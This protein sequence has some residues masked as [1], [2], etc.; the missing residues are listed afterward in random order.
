MSD[1]RSDVRAIRYLTWALVVLAGALAVTAII[2]AVDNP[3]ISGTT[4]GDSYPCL[5]PWDTVLNGANNYPGGEPPTDG[6]DIK[7]RCEA[8]GRER[9]G[10]AVGFGVGAAILVGAAVAVTLV[11]DRRA[12]G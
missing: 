2:L 8:A 6:D 5:A 7:T 11:G 9:F 10:H 12:G 4:R 3:E 1:D